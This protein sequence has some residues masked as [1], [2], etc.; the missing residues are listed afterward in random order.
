MSRAKAKAERVEHD[1]Y[2]T[3]GWAVHRLL[4]AAG[5]ALGFSTPINATE[6]LSVLEPCI[7]DGAI[8]RAVMAWLALRE[9]RDLG[10]KAPA[11]NW[12]GV[13]LR[14]GAVHESTPPL[15]S[16]AEGADYRSHA[17]QWAIDLIL[18]NPPFGIAEGF[19]RKALEDAPIVAMLL[20]L[21]IFESAERVRLWRTVPQPAVYVL[22]DRPSFDGVATDATAYGW[23]VWGTDERGIHVLDATARS[24]RDAYKP[25][26]PTGLPQQTLGLDT[27]DER[28]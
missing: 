26:K 2:P 22:P 15:A 21:A 27:N 5:N 19:I 6:P 13:E 18:T 23:I 7:G 16:L 8:V 3:P 9:R 12:H 17:I 10:Y 11:I 4:D 20:R 1:F 24:I 28:D 14:R 25:I